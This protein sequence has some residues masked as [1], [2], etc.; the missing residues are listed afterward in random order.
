MKNVF[1]RLS[2][3]IL[4]VVF[5]LCFAACGGTEPAPANGS[6][7]ATGENAGTKN[8]PELVKLVENE[9]AAFE[10]SFEDSFGSSS[11][12]IECD[13]KL[14]VDGTKL[15]VDCL[16]AGVDEV[17]EETRKEMQEAY[18]AT[19]EELSEAFKPI[20]DEAP[21][22]TEVILNICEEDGDVIA[23]VKMPF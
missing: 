2:C 1:K 8:D 4:V 15:I 13:C 23:I 7:P 18:D 20:K 5:V 14:S 6:A 3:L 10:K 9:G 11:G 17:P 16:V 22:L 19:A 21:S 12:G